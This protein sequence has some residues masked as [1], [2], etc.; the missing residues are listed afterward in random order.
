MPYNFSVFQFCDCSYLWLYMMMQFAVKTSLSVWQETKTVIT[1]LVC[2]L[3]ANLKACLRSVAG[4]SST[5]LKCFARTP[6]KSPKSTSVLPSLF[7]SLSICFMSVLLGLW[8]AKHWFISYAMTAEI[9][10]EVKCLTVKAALT[11]FSLFRTQSLI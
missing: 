2:I 7:S 4:S 9:P 6:R 3:S 11:S 8:P 10:L 1:D 5:S